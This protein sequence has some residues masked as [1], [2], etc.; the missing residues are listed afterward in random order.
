[1]IRLKNRGLVIGR[2]RFA[3]RAEELIEDRPD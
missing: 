3:V 1:L 2:A